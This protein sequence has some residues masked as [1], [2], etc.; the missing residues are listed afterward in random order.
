MTVGIGSKIHIW[1][2]NCILFVSISTLKA[3]PAQSFVFT[4]V[5]VKTDKTSG[6]KNR[7]H[8]ECGDERTCHRGVHLDVCKVCTRLWHVEMTPP[9]SRLETLLLFGEVQ[10]LL[11]ILRKEHWP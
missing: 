7:P 5:I 2:G 4:P 11:G 3:A 10:T 6:R 8:Q 9:C 1:S